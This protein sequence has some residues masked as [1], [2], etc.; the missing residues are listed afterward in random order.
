MCCGGWIHRHAAPQEGVKIQTKNSTPDFF[1]FF[2]SRQMIGELIET[3]V[4][5][6]SRLKPCRD[7]RLTGRVVV[8][9]SACLTPL[10]LCGTVKV[11]RHESLISS[12]HILCGL[13][14]TFILYYIILLQWVLY[15]CRWRKS[16]FPPVLSPLFSSICSPW[17]LNITFPSP[18]VGP[19]QIW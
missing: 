6:T 3:N 10:F 7:D 5:L 11:L 12:K 16:T 17:H 2:S 14:F 8:F 15:R 19:T 18:E 1:F 9:L 13:R 4:R